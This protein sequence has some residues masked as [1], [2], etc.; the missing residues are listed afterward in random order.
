MVEAVAAFADG[1][2]DELRTPQGES[3]WPTFRYDPE[4]EQAA[5]EK[6]E[7]GEYGCYTE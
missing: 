2:L 5:I 3:D 6:L 4:I 1:R 7:R